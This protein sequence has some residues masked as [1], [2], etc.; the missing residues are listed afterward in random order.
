MLKNAK[1]HFKVVTLT[2]VLGKAKQ[3]FYQARK[4]LGAN[5]FAQENLNPLREKISYE[6]RQLTRSRTL[7]NTWVAGCKVNAKLPG[8]DGKVITLRDMIDIQCLKDG[9]P[10]PEYD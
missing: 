8:H 4:D 5:I 9:N 7:N 6:A 3:S 10:L 2:G 1:Y